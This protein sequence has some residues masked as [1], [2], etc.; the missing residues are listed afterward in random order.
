[1]KT[2]CVTIQLLSFCCIFFWKIVKEVL[3]TFKNF[4]FAKKMFWES[5]WK[6]LNNGCES[7]QT[8]FSTTQL[9]SLR[10]NLSLRNDS[11]HRMNVSI[12]LGLL[13]GFSAQLLFET[14]FKVAFETTW[15]FEKIVFSAKVVSKTSFLLWKL[16]FLQNLFLKPL[17]EEKRTFKSCW[18]FQ[19]NIVVFWSFFFN[20][21]FCVSFP[22]AVLK[23]RPYSPS[24][25]HGLLI[26]ILVGWC[27]L[28]HV[29]SIV[30]YIYIVSGGNV[31]IPHLSKLILAFSGSLRVDFLMSW[32]ISKSLCAD[33]SGWLCAKGAVK[34]SSQDCF[35]RTCKRMYL[36]LA[37]IV[38]CLHITCNGKMI[39]IWI[40]LTH[41]SFACSNHPPACMPTETQTKKPH[42]ITL[43]SKLLKPTQTHSNWFP[44]KFPWQL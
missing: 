1:M 36:G 12:T 32:Q 42:Q 8:S 39:V 4:A 11:A 27:T 3:Q 29:P 38:A 22:Q 6:L 33:E 20:T 14:S 2:S 13:Y 7:L 34:G 28:G 10:N 31:S 30:Y 5:F 23:P 15:N 37:V 43:V 25:G 21:D 26:H 35:A 17:F 24:L 16:L 44:W 9:I 18:K 41:F 19:K 40:V